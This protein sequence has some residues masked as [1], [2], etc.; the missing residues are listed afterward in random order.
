MINIQKSFL[1]VVEFKT[2]RIEFK[3]H[4]S[5]TTGV[6]QLLCVLVVESDSLM[7]MRKQ[8]DLNDENYEAHITLAE[9]FLKINHSKKSKN[10][11]INDLNTVLSC[12]IYWFR[13]FT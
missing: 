6:S 1:L 13:I 12:F 2:K 8:M 7:K 4:Y 3:I 5:K 9:K 10:S 11:L